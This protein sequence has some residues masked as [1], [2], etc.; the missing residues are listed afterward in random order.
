MGKAA[1]GVD[2]R[3]YPW[4]EEISCTKANYRDGNNFCVGETI[5]VG[6]YETGKSIYG[7]YDMVGNVSEW[8]SSLSRS[9]PYDA[10]DVRENM[11]IVDSR[12]VRGGSWNSSS[13]NVRSANRSQDAPTWAEDLYGFRCVLSP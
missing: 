3:T 12:V 11:S 9:Y 8:V 5:E 1:R 13:N 6:S 4:G 2:G 7:T 10:S